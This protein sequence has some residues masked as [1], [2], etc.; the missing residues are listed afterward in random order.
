MTEQPM[1]RDAYDV[2]ID[3]ILEGANG[4]VRLALRA[5]LIES[6]HLE[7][8]LLALSEKTSSRSGDAGP[9]KHLLN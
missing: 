5:L 7:A 8:R 1:D 9:A 6:L 3:R 4:D 2:A